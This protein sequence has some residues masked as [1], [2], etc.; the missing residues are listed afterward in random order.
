MIVYEGSRRQRGGNIFGTIRRMIIPH[1]RK[2]GRDLVKQGLNVG[3]GAITD[4]LRNKAS[5]QDSLKERTAQ[6]LERVSAN[7][8]GETQDGA[9]IKSINNKKTPGKRKTLRKHQPDVFD[10]K[11]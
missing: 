3:V 8:F 10:K 7:A 9:G 6:A 4:K 2:A 5:I 1:A 11:P